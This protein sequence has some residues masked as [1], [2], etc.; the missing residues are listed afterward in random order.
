MENQAA[1][2]APCPQGGTVEE[3]NLNFILTK[4]K[5]LY[6][7][8]KTLKAKIEET[9]VQL[10][11]WEQTLIDKFTEEGLQNVKSGIGTF[12]IREDYF[13]SYDRSR[14]TEVFSFMREEGEGDLIRETINSRTLASWAK[15]KEE[16]G[17]ELPDFFNITRKPRIGVRAK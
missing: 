5:E 13:A 7:L 11:Q 17:Y 10:D 4:F 12:Y 3:V 15:E 14:E 16:E 1:Y 6:D 8:K 9:Q 2:E